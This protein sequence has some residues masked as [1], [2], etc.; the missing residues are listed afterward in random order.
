MAQKFVAVRDEVLRYLKLKGIVYLL[1]D[2][3]DR[4]WTPTGFAEVDTLIIIGFVECLQDIRKRFARSKIE[5]SM[6]YFP[7]K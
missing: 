3:L 7:S 2:N 4:F 5:F 1:F 6:G